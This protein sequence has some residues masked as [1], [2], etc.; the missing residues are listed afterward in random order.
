MQLHWQNYFTGAQDKASLDEVKKKL[1][2][3]IQA[4]LKC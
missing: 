4:I 3:G 1:E 2:E